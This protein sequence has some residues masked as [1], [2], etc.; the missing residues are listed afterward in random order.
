MM[1][2]RKRKFE[3]Y[4]FYD[5]TGIET[6]LRNMAAKG[7]MIEKISNQYWTYRKI[8]PTDMSFSVSYYAKAS[9]F[10]PQP[11]EGQ[12]RFIDYCE[13]T[14]WKLACRWF[15]MQVFYNTATDATPIHTDPVLEVEAIHKGCKSNFLK[16]Y[17][18]MALISLIL[19][20][21]SLSGFIGDFL[22]CLAEPAKFSYGI[23]V[24]LLFALCAVDLISYY[25]WLHRARKLAQNDIFLETPSTSGFQKAIILLCGLSLAWCLIN[26]LLAKNVLLAWTSFGILGCVILLQILVPAI[27]EWMKKRNVSAVANI[28]LTL[29]AC[30]ILS[31]ILMGGV[32][33]VELHVINQTGPNPVYLNE[34]LR[35]SD[36]LDDVPV[37]FYRESHDESLLLARHEVIP[38]PYFENGEE[39][40]PCPYLAYTQIDVKIPAMQGFCETVLRWNMKT[41]VKWRGEVLQEDAS[42][43]GADQAWKLQ[44]DRT[45][46]QYLL[47]YENTLVRLKLDWEP[48]S[49]QCATVGKVFLKEGIAQ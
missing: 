5:K 6:H 36:L 7:W 29:A 27:K 31:F 23:C 19:A 13:Q 35:A 44:A 33:M 39:G 14:G 4:S 37:L 48:N 34:S 18:I 38:R 11:R 22:L 41:S 9:D 17:T 16:S 30:F 32:I 46:M 42:R 28:A 2:N 3:C 26:I 20:G 1:K 25:R 12:Q 10:D 15:Q 8:E 49:Q 40:D 43:W 45:Y 24:I 21:L 47:V